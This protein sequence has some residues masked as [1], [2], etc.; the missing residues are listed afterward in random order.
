MTNLLP[1]PFCTLEESND[2]P[3]RIVKDNG[4]F[5]VQCGYCENGLYEDSIQEAIDRWNTRSEITQNETYL[6]GFLDCKKQLME[7]IDRLY[8]QEPPKDSAV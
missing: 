3:P 1:C 6:K 8:S 5:I 2:H 4:N 7:M